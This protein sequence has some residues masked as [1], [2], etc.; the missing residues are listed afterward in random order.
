MKKG[1]L[2]LGVILVLSSFVFVQ[3]SKDDDVENGD[4]NGTLA[5]KIT[6]APSDDTNIKG[7][8]ITV[9]DVKVDGKSVEGFTQQTIE[10]SAYQNGNAKL[11]F[12]HELEAKTYNSITLV[13]DYESDA[14]G[15]SPGCY[16]LT[17]DNAKHDLTASS[18]AG[19]EVTV[20]KPFEVEANSQTSLVID[21]DLR[22][23]IARDEQS[24]ES[25]YR[26]VS[27]TDLQAAVRVVHEDKTGEISGQVS[28]LAAS[29]NDMYVFAYKKGSFDSTT[30]TQGQGSGN[31]FFYN[32]VSSARVNEDGSYTLA[33]LEEGDYE[34]HVASYT[35]SGESETV[36]EGMLN[37]TSSIQGVVLSNISVSASADR[38]SVV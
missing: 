2:L 29:D 15:S 17:D 9:A 21:F 16:V 33:F 13:L 23:S 27:K 32:A 6:D 24:A 8:F 34:I 37:A 26:F 31:V 19:G 7:T 1:K 30:E 11:I 18:S 22:R 5:V 3:C 28:A 36:F 10:I 38:K 4:E 35:A 25:D 12:N 14:S 20:S